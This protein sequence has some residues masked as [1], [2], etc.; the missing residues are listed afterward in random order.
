MDKLK[1]SS[2][3]SLAPGAKKEFTVETA[4]VYNLE[5][6]GKFNVFSTGTIPYAKEG[7]TSIYGSLTYKSNQI[8]MNIDGAQAA[9]VPKLRPNNKRTI[10]DEST[11]SAAQIATLK[12]GFSNCEKMAT[13][14]AKDVSKGKYIQEYFR[15]PSSCMRRKISNRFSK[16]A[17]DCS[18]RSRKTK[19][20]CNNPLNYCVY[21]GENVLAYTDKRTNII[22]Y[23]P[24]FWETPALPRPTL[25]GCWKDNQVSVIIHEE[26]HAPAIVRSP[27][28][29]FAK[30]EGVF[31]IGKAKAW[32]NADNYGA[33]AVGKLHIIWWRS[34]LKLI[35]I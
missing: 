8:T 19:T 13:A 14:A 25:N 24:K 33:Y 29:D 34:A 6:G 12:E 28:E 20:V 22:N 17:A 27:T 31:M 26:T 7:S 15:S 1:P 35:N 3:L 21:R 5:R 10:I 18:L 9:K 2:F 4:N 16:V 23:C 32:Q 11:C 30:M